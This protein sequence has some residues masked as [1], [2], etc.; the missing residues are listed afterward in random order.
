MLIFGI[1]FGI[2]AVITW[3]NF[4][5][6]LDRNTLFYRVTVLSNHSILWCSFYLLGHVWL[7]SGLAGFPFGLAQGFAPSMVRASHRNLYQFSFLSFF[8]RD[9]RLR[10]NRITASCSGSFHLLEC[11]RLPLALPSHSAV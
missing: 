1:A 5:V 2:Y 8:L 6:K 10:T 4:V 11:S 7:L 9:R 3:S